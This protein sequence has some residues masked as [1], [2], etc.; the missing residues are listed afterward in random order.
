MTPFSCTRLCSHFA[1]IFGLILV[2]S[3]ARAQ[4]LNKV[5]I[6]E[7]VLA[8][9]TDHGIVGPFPEILIEASHRIGQEIEII[10]LPWRRAQ[11]L[12]QEEAG[13]GAATVTR[14][15]SRESLYVWV[16]EYMPLRLTFFVKK[17][18]PLHPKS[19]EDL[20]GVKVAVEQGSA[21]D[22]FVRGLPGHSIK[23]EPVTR[24]GLIPV[25]MK[26][27]RVEGWLIWDIIGMENFRQQNMLNDVRR[28]FSHELGP[29]YLAT[30]PTVSEASLEQWR[31]ALKEMKADGTIQKILEHHYGKLASQ[32]TP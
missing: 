14:I 5:Y 32:N 24:P 20:N 12:A 2:C 30:N 17:D 25:M 10:P 29:I 6:G 3:P 1:L 27:D 16:E 13:A 8:Q 28:T 4:T 26:T 11:V 18:S 7:G 15:P 22:Y 23:I 31:A 21:A 19:L 9:V